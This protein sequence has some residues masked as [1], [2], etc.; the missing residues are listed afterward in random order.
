MLGILLIIVLLQSI[1][2]PF[3]LYGADSS[4]HHPSS[5][6]DYSIHRYDHP[7]IEK[8]VLFIEELTEDEESSIY[9]SAHSGEIGVSCFNYFNSSYP[10]LDLCTWGITEFSYRNSFPIYLWVRNLRI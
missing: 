3:G 6:N 7:Q 10:S 5:T 2:T 4:Q 9:H 8:V 1:L